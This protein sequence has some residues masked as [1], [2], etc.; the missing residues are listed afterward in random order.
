MILVVLKSD[1]YVLHNTPVKNQI[2]VKNHWG[3]DIPDPLQFTDPHS[4]LYDHSK[5]VNCFKSCLL[6][7]VYDY[8]LKAK[9]SDHSL[10][11]LQLVDLVKLSYVL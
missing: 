2:C 4:P 5:P 10:I 9:N 6:S 8:Y 11:V 3:R 7:M 1:Y